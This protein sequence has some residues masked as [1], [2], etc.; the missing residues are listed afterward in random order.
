MLDAKV[1]GSVL[2][3]LREERGLSQEIVS[4]LA[5][6]G[7]THLSAIERGERKPT[8]ETFYR[9]GEALHMRPSAVLAEIEAELEE[10]IKYFKERDMLLEAQRIE[11]RTR[12]DLE[13][14]REIGF[15]YVTAFED[16]KPHFISL[17]G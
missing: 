13:M 7:R 3:R 17:E 14:L 15:R 2:Q 8:L 16:R 12:Y 9:I 6:I 1:V 11:Q 5:G 10:R 4:G